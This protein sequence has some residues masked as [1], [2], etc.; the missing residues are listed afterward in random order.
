M[1]FIYIILRNIPPL[2]SLVRARGSTHTY[3]VYRFWWLNANLEDLEGEDEDGAGGDVGA[4]LTVAVRDLAGDGELP[5]VTLLHHLHRLGPARDHLV[6]SEGGGLAAGVRGVEL[7]AVDG[8]AAVV[9][10][11]GGVC[12]GAGAA[13]EVRDQRV[14]AFPTQQN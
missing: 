5:L 12:L 7:L 6:G 2:G 3:D 13:L 8:G 10:R 1:L 9:A 11:A 4:H 14:G